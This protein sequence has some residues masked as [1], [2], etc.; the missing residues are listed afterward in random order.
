MMQ[1]I[2]IALKELTFAIDKYDDTLWSI[3][4]ADYNTLMR[5]KSL[6]FLLCVTIR[7]GTTL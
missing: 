4:H 2:I 6:H 5:Y 3:W 1:L 7:S